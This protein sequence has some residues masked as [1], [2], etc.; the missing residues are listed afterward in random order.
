MHFSEAVGT[1]LSHLRISESVKTALSHLEQL[2]SRTCPTAPPTPVYISSSPCTS[3]QGIKITKS[4]KGKYITLTSPLSPAALMAD[5]NNRSQSSFQ[6]SLTQIL[7][8]SQYSSQ[9]ASFDQSELSHEV[10]S[11]HQLSLGPVPSLCR[12]LQRWDVLKVTQKVNR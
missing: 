6:L 7:D 5:I 3:Q 11:I 10:K 4:R 9:A 12:G 8:V 2:S 1:A